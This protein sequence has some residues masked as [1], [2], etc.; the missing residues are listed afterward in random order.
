MLKGVVIGG[1]WG[2]GENGEEME[3]YKEVVMK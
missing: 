2:L 1:R 3:K